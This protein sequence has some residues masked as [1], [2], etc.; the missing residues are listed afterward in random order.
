VPRLGWQQVL[1]PGPAILSDRIFQRWLR[2]RVGRVWIGYFDRGLDLL[3]ADPGRATH[4]EKQTRFCVNRILPDG[5]TGTVGGSDG[6]R[7]GA[8]NADAAGSRFLTR[9]TAYRGPCHGRRHLPRWLVLGTPA[10]LT[11]LDG[12]GARSMYAFHGLVNNHV[13]PWRFGRM[14]SG[15]HAGRPF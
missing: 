2:T 4:V 6:K 8:F 7:A 13:T 1:K 9:A 12:S 3:E 5:R 15:S 10:G 14:N 11:F